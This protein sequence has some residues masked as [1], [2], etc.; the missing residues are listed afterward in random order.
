MHFYQVARK[1]EIAP[2]N[3]AFLHVRICPLKC[4]WM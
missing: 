1:W 4:I 2:R 3:T